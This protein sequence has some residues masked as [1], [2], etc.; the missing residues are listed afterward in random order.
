[1]V[2]WMKDSYYERKEKEK[3]EPK[4]KTKQ[5]IY[6]EERGLEN[7][8]PQAKEGVRKIVGDLAGNGFIK[9]GMAFS[10]AKAEEQA[11][12]SY[13]SAIT[14]QNWIMIQQQDAM[15]QEMKRANQK[16]SELE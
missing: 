12:V 4:K 13:L 15:L 14:E 6:L 10:F 7:L 2:K 1:M 16:E 3:L 5:D 8:S 9:A 11:K